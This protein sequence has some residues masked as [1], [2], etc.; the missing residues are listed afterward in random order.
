MKLINNRPAPGEK[1]SADEAA[2]MR[3]QA[4][5]LADLDIPAEAEIFGE[6]RAR[7]VVNLNE[8]R[9]KIGIAPLTNDESGRPE[10]TEQRRAA[11]ERYEADRAAEQTRRASFRL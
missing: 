9:A 1:L 5:G 8:A 10:L 7:K 6:D 2:V 3:R 11:N 4:Q